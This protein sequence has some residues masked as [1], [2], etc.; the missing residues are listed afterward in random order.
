M[1][2]LLT[3]AALAA[4]PTMA[5]D[6]LRTWTIE[7]TFDAFTTDELGNVY[8]LR[9]DELEL[10]DPQGRSWL[11]N[12]LKTFG[13]ITAMDAFYS[14]KP[15]VFSAEQGQIAVLDNTLSVQGSVINLP[16]QGY[17]QVVMACMSVQNGFWFFDQRELALMR[18]DAQ[19]RP[20]A[21]TGRLDQLLGHP[22]SPAGMQEHE[23]RLYVNDPAVGI[24]VLDLFGTYAKTIPI[25]HAD[26]FEVRGNMLYF[27]AEGRLQVYDMRSF[28]IA[29]HPLPLVPPG[30][31]LNARVERGRLYLRLADRLVI[32]ETTGS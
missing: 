12:S 8:A 32:V 28:A 10:Y 7:G 14:L 20:L 13:R 9:G 23:S 6:S 16:R 21:N 11:R 29:D 4:L 18:M 17:P 5:Q 15:M 2:S 3:I 1:K 31:V 27:F 22:V 24:L 26:S 25:R 30:E 19:L